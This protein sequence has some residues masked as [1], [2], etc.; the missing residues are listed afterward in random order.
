MTKMGTFPSPIFYKY[1]K[2]CFCMENKYSEDV[3]EEI[4]SILKELIV[5]L[6]KRAKVTENEKKFLFTNKNRD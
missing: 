1:V 5:V 3:G 6:K 2:N 4:I